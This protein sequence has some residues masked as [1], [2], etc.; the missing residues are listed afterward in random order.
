MKTILE[1]SN[2]SVHI[3]TREGILEAVRE[4]SLSLYEGEVLAIVGESGSGKSVLCKS[5]MKLDPRNSNVKVERI[6][7]NGIDITNYSEHRMRKLRGTLFSII[8]QDPMSSLNPTLI[9][10][11]QIE[12]SYAI[13]NPKSSKEER[14]HK[15]I[16]LM[17]L[18]GITNAKVKYAMYPYQFSGGTRQRIVIAMALASEAKILF[19]DEPTT[20][21]DVT[22]QAQILDL[23][24][25]VQRKMGMGMVFVTHDFAMVA[26]IADRV[27]VMYAGKIV[28]IGTVD[29]IFYAPRHPYTKALLKA[30][31]YFAKENQELYTI[32][33]MPPSLVEPPKGDLF[34][35]RNV[36][37][38][39]IDY[40]E[41]P[42]M[43][44]VSESHFAATW[45]LSE[46][47]KQDMDKLE[48]INE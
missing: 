36:E 10:G 16:S 1:V 9:V 5:M 38:L 33:G 4:V 8:L 17:E 30:L 3:P 37:A 23:L 46:V 47:R 11:K 20:A 6:V 35:Y 26:R 48:V 27:A 45:L 42:P 19:A 21:L 24:R 14:Y 2:L 39:E 7:A 18:V 13:K 31:P 34:A 15:V 22:M 25:E 29:E 40:I 44:Q 28:E 32:P 43:F 12:E 41:M